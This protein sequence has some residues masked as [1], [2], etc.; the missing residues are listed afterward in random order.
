MHIGFITLR[1]V[2]NIRNYLGSS[3]ES[4]PNNF[5]G[6]WREFLHVRVSIALDVPLKIRMKFKENDA[7]KCWVNFKYEVI[8]TFCFFCCKIGHA[9]KFC[10]KLFDTPAEMIEMPY[11]VWMRAEP[12]RRV[13]TICAKWLRPGGVSPAIGKEVDDGGSD[14]VGGNFSTVT[15]LGEKSRIMVIK[16]MI[17]GLLLEKIMGL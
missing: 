7:S 3:T 6:V 15:C 17:I 1:V 9:E 11:A 13:H 2:T 12:R 5:V 16:G 4:D 10:E 8:P 14:P